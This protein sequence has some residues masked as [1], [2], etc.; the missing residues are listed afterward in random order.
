MEQWRAVKA[1]SGGVD[2]ITGADLYLLDEEQDPD[3]DPH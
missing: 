2:G 3:P 1:H